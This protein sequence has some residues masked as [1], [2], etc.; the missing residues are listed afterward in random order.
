MATFFNNTVYLDDNFLPFSCYFT[1]LAN[2]YINTEISLTKDST[3][4]LEPVEIDSKS[5]AVQK[6]S[7]FLAE[8]TNLFISLPQYP[9]T[10]RLLIIKENGNIAHTIATLDG[11]MIDQSQA[12]VLSAGSTIKLFYNGS[13]WTIL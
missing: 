1:D 13:N 7:L 3:T 12:T 6:G 4:L 11:T 2:L 5:F 9:Q 10:G 8:Q